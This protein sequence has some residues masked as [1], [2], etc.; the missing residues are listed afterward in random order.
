MTD[1][2]LQRIK[3]AALAS[4]KCAGFPRDGEYCPLGLLRRVEFGD[5][6]CG[7]FPGPAEEYKTWQYEVELAIIRAAEEGRLEYAFERGRDLFVPETYQRL[8]RQSENFQRIK[9]Q[10]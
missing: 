2:T 5:W 3:K 9:F 4:G 7:K 6:T 1:E 8:G 10:G